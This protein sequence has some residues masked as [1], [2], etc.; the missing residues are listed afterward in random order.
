VFNT[1]EQMNGPA[2]V[3]F[4]N[5][6]SINQTVDL[7][8]TLKA[9]ATAGTYRGYWMLK[10]ASG[11][12]FGIGTSANKPFWVE[13]KVSGTSAGSVVYDFV[14]NYCSAQWNT[15]AGLRPCPGAQ[16][17][18]EG[19]VLKQD[20]PV[21]EN[22]VTSSTPGLLVA[23]QNIYNGYIQGVYPAVTVQNGDRFQT[24]VGCQ[25]G[26]VNCNVTYRLDYR[27]G[28]GPIQTFWVF[29]EVY[30]G[31]VY[32]ADL[33]LNRLAGQNVQFIL[34]VL[35]TGSATDDRAYWVGARVYRP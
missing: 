19:F 12:L 20:A 17:D 27:I 5:N 10:N 7:S 16:D 9:P 13:I 29:R 31:R 14:N 11:A 21:P 35:A 18:A 23:P 32:Q 28:S 26:H 3:N 6:V 15:G 22:G 8:V 1:G 24:T 4:P 2:A 34:T 25:S 33:N 30:E